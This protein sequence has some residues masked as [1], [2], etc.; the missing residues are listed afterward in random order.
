MSTT[1]TRSRR[2]PGPK[3][4]SKRKADLPLWK[5]EEARLLRLLLHLLDES[6]KRR[7]S[8][9]EVGMATEARKRLRELWDIAE[10]DG[11]LKFPF[12]KR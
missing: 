5:E 12:A 9:V 4:G 6:E 7:I 8:P 2:K 10:A 1:S 11:Q 3:K